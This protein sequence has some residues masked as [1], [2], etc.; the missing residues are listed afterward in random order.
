MPEIFDLLNSN[1][2]TLIETIKNNLVASGQNATGETADSLEQE[3]K[4]EGTKFIYALSGRPFFMTVQT[5]RRP[6]PDKKP[7]RS[8]ISNIARWVDARGMDESAVWAIAT[9]IQQKGTKLW[10]DGGRTDIVNP[11]IDEFINTVS[12]ELLDNEAERFKIKIDELVW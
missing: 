1:G 11:A 2:T 4:K 5:G 8:M 6:T 7:S 10:Q 12:N 3:I 9:S